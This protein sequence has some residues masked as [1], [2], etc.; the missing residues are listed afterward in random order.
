MPHI[1]NAK[2][3]AEH[4]L[5]VLRYLTSSECR[6][7]IFTLLTDS[8]HLN[9]FYVKIRYL[10]HKHNST[11]VSD[12]HQASLTPRWTNHSFIQRADVLRL[13]I[14]TGWVLEASPSDHYWRRNEVGQWLIFVWIWGCEA[15]CTQLSRWKLGKKKHTPTMAL[16][17][18]HSHY[19]APPPAPRHLT[20]S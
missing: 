11:M 17:A 15:P 14:R 18:P 16:L 3:C 7:L 10:P 2:I 1:K 20:I 4:H 8:N 6:S 12:L 9:K 13:S 5:S 19:G